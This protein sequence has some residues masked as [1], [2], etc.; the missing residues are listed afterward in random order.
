MTDGAFPCP[1]DPCPGFMAQP[2]RCWQMVYSN[3][4]QATHCTAQPT[5]TGRWFSPCGKRWWRVWSCADHL[6]GLTRIRQFGN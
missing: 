3:Q 4:L 5:H 1:G 2:G 6:N